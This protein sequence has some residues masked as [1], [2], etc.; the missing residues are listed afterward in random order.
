VVSAGVFDGADEGTADSVDA[1]GDEVGA[2][3]GG[4]AGGQIL[5]A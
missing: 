4:D 2:A 1:G 3:W 5:G